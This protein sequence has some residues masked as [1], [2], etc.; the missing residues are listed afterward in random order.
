MSGI[1]I[2]GLLLVAALVVWVA[3]QSLGTQKKSQTM[4]SQMSELRRELQTVATA[5]AQA[6]GQIS[7]MATTVTQRL[8]TVSRSLTDGVAQSADIS[9]KGQTAMRDELKSTQGMMERIHKQLGEFQEVSRGLSNAQ[10][11]LESVLGGA[12]TRGILGEVA[13][14]RLLE[15]SLPSSQYA[16]QYRFA[17][18]EAVDA[19]ILLRDKKL[20]AIDSK[21]PLDAFRRIQTDGDEARRA[22]VTAVKLH[23]D[24]IAKKYILPA[25]NTLD[26]ALM[27]VPSESVYYE[28]L[29]CVDNKGQQLDAYCR[30]RH[31]VAVSPNTLYAHLSVIAMGLRGMQIE[32]NARR[33]ANG[34]AGLKKQFEN[35][36][37]VFERIG[38]HLKNA[39]QSYQEA[40]KRFDKTTN[41]LEGMLSPGS[42]PRSLFPE[43]DVL[44][45]PSVSSAK[46]GG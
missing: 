4:E 12:K 6:A 38:N 20:L 1:V 8:D 46:S 25:E 14:E 40:D 28:L 41:S 30:D 10:Q 44:P 18:G 17:S 34:L 24:S 23:A 32:E 3:L 35:F 7:A 15:D 11:S 29:Q 39:Q 43:D 21:F 19:V 2:A 5:Q 37:E 36:S 42:V 26:L 13:L 45:L 31:I 9:A 22:F 16:T 33:L 27:F